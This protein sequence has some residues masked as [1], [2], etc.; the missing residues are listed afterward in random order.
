MLHDLEPI[1]N[2]IKNFTFFKDLNKEKILMLCKG[3]QVIVSKHRENLFKFG[4][5]ADHFGLVLSGAYRLSRPTPHGEESVLYFST[6]GDVIAAFI[7]N[8]PDPVYPVTATA[9]GTSRFLKIPRVMYT[10]Q[11]MS[12]MNLIMEIQKS[13]STRMIQ[14]QTHKSFSG[15][16]IP[17]RIALLLLELSGKKTYQ[18][19]TIHEL[20]IPLTRKEISDT[21]DVTVESVIR[22]MSQWS[23]QGIITSNDH[24]IQITDF[25]KIK[26]ISEA[27]K[28]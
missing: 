24:I 25:E 9:M 17:Q 4:E 12:N 8:R 15:S 16:S 13:L 22:V 2:E 20:P 3:G 27:V 26:S 10:T 23:K 14:L 11:W 28:G 5:K 1:C 21:L 6:P 7:M 19:L 18:S